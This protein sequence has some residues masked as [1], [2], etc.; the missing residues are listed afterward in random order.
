VVLDD[1]HAW[2]PLDFMLRIINHTSL[3]VDIKGGVT[4]FLAKRIFITSNDPWDEW[5]NWGN[6]RRKSAFKRRLTHFIDV[7]RP[8]TYK[9]LLCP[10]E[11]PVFCEEES[12]EEPPTKKIKTEGKENVI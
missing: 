12:R 3:L 7:T 6:E 4:Q 10:Q 9:S 1:F 5:Y 8:E 2:L 11:K